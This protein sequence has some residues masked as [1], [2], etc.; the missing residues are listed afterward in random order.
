MSAGGG[1][2][3]AEEYAVR[4]LELAG[5]PVRVTSYRL[6]GQYHAAVE[7]RAAG[8]RIARGSG[9]TREAA[10]REALEKARARLERTRRG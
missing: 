1:P 7:E 2:L 5:W 6:A 8:A 9:A 4:D 10:E 3:R